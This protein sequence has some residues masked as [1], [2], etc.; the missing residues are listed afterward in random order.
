MMAAAQEINVR[1]VK[2]TMDAVALQLSI[3]KKTLY[4]YFSSK[5]ELI[6]AMIDAA[7]QDM[8]KQTREIMENEKDFAARLIAIVTLEPKVFGKVS[9]W[10]RDD[11][12]R[13][14]P[15]EW[16]KVERF[17]EG[18]S[19][20]VARLLEEG[21]ASGCIRPISVPVAVQMLHSACGMLLQYEFLAANNLTFSEGLQQ[22]KDIF[23]YGV[24]RLDYAG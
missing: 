9:D 17:S 7:I 18:S 1:G 16:E 19:A 14:R 10:A 2:F 4:R 22:L 20:L 13:C 24:M 5:D 3:S 8:E 21:I 23:L 6:G 15:K 12:R 11:I